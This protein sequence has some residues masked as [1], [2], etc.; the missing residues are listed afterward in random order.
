MEEQGFERLRAGDA[1][2]DRIAVGENSPGVSFIRAGL[3]QECLGAQAVQLGQWFDLEE[4]FF[5]QLS[6]HR[7]VGVLVRFGERIPCDSRFVGVFDVVGQ[8]H[9][10]NRI[11]GEGFHVERH[12]AGKRP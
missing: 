4:T 5:F 11:V 8:I 7:F 10:K 9:R 2:D 12:G 1:S 6:E 3:A